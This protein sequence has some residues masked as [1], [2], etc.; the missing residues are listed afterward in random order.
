M[1]PKG[2]CKSSFSKL[3][4]IKHGYAF[5]G[6]FFQNEPNDNILLT[7]GNFH[8]NQRLYFGKKT[9]YYNG[10]IP[11]DYVLKNNDLLIVMT[12]LTKN[13]AILGNSVIL[14]SKKTVLHN[15]RI[16]KVIDLDTEKLNIEFLNLLLNS[17]LVRKRVKV[18]STGTT[19]R[20]TS[21]TKILSIEVLYPPLEEQIKI[22]E[23]ISIWDRQIL[24]LETLI[25]EKILKKKGIMQELLNTSRN[26]RFEMWQSSSIEDLTT[27]INDGTH[28]TPKYVESGVPFYSVESITRN[29]FINTKYISEEEHLKLIK[30]C[31]PEKNNILMTR[32]GALGETKRIDWDVNA[33]IYVS[34]VLMKIDEGKISNN[35]FYAYTK[36][37]NF[38]REIIKRSLLNAAPQKINLGEVRKVIIHYPESR[39]DQEKIASIILNSESE[40]KLLECKKKL[41]EKQ[42]AG[43]IQKLLS[44]EIRVQ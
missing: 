14:K 15:Q 10:D 26:K 21:P 35:Y 38:K 23:I 9:K 7:P 17:N 19:V 2:W 8:I 40:I 29:D 43:L 1:I 12:D 36:S 37:F 32:I 41:L 16:G 39:D 24:L 28:S 3:F 4:K 13:M 20:H 27:Y 18:T 33:S 22:V 42:R 31:K 30:R 6:E 34:L 44:G 25:K 5:K 11:S